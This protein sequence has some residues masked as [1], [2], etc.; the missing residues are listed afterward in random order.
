MPRRA[1]AV[2]AAKNISNIEEDENEI[3]NASGEDFQQND[4]I[5][6]NGAIILME[7][8]YQNG[9]ILNRVTPLKKMAPFY[10]VDDQAITECA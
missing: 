7:F 3:D 2:E 4:V 8:A 5:L 9:A 6:Q 10:G 1:A